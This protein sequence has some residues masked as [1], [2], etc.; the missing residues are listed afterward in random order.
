MVQIKNPANQYIPPINLRFTQQIIQ[1]MIVLL[2]Q[3]Q[4]LLK[5]QPTKQFQLINLQMFPQLIDLSVNSSYD[6]TWPTTHPTVTPTIKPTTQPTICQQL[7]SHIISN[8]KP[9]LHPI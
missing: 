7:L 8:H 6:P 5:Y 9:Y 2:D 4:I 1:L 3:Q